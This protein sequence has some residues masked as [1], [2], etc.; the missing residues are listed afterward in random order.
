MRLIG[1]RHVR[2]AALLVMLV[3]S[4]AKAAAQTGSLSV[5]VYEKAK[6]RRE[7]IPGA[8][9]ELT[10]PQ[11][12][13]RPQSRLTGSDGTAVFAE[14]PAGRGFSISVTAGG[15]SPAVQT[16][17]QITAGKTTTLAITLLS[18]QTDEVTIVDKR[19]VVDVAR[20]ESI[21]NLSAEYFNDLPVYGRDYQNVLVLAPGVND[22]DGDGNVTVHGSR[23]RD[24]KVT[25]DGV[26][27]VD[28]LTGQRLSQINPDAIDEIQI[29]DTGADLSMG[30]AVGGYA[31]LTIKSGGN[32]FEGSSSLYWVDAA[33]NN[34]GSGDRDPAPFIRRKPS[35]YVSGPIVRDQLWYL[36]T[37]EAAQISEPIN[38]IGGADAVQ[39]S[40]GRTELAKLTWQV[41]GKSR[42]SIQYSADPLK[43]E[44]SG[45]T[46]LIPADSAADYRQGGPT[47][48]MRWTATLSPTS[49]WESTA[50]FSDIEYGF[51]PHNPQARNS[52]A[53]GSIDG[54]DVSRLRCTDSATGFL[55]GPYP[56]DYSDTRQRRSYALDGTKFFGA[57][58]S[59]GT[60]DIKYGML[61]E[62][63]YFQRDQDSRT[64]LFKA[65]V[66]LQNLTG[67][68][69]NNL[70]YPASRLQLTRYFP[71]TQVNDVRGNNLA[72]YLTD[73][74]MPTSN[75]VLSVGLRLNREELSAD[76]FAP[77]DPVEERRVFEKA[78]GEC[79]AAGNNSAVCVAINS[80]LFTADPEDNPAK[81]GACSVALNP[82]QCAYLDFARQAGRSLKFRT[83][84][85]YTLVNNNLSRTVRVSWDPKANAR[86]Q[87]SAAYTRL[88]GDAFFEPFVTEQG[89]RALTNAY[90]VNEEGQVLP[91]ATETG[92]AFQISQ[93]DRNLNSQYQ[94]EV[95][96]EFVHEIASETSIRLRYV[97][98]RYE[99]QY[100]D[101]DINH[102]PVYYDDLTPRQLS[103]FSRCRRIGEFADC[104]GQN[105]LQVA[106][107]SARFRELPDGI[108][109][110]QLA[111]PLFNNI[112]LIGNYNSSTYE[113]YVF[114]LERRFYQNWEGSL[115]Y[116]WSR[117]MG[118]AEDF[119]QTLGNDAT[120]TDDERGPLAI[121]QTHVV[122]LNGRVLIG[123]WG[124]F[125]LGA[126]VLYASGLPYSIT[127]PRAVIDFPTDLTGG[128]GFERNE[129]FETQRNVFPTGARNDRR[130]SAAW[131]CD[132]NFQKEFKLERAK[133]TFQVGAFN[134]LNSNE[135]QISGVQRTQ[136][137]NGARTVYRDTPSA[138]RA[139]GRYFEVAIKL[140]F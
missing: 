13:F 100:Q 44:P 74:F 72:L 130:N 67:G 8:T 64:I 107:G 15:Y 53:T 34:D 24:F 85:P 18:A 19:P 12:T 75:L 97:N 121:D 116:V 43:Q 1:P 115:S 23:E 120:N 54:A 49:V 62:R 98:R 40:R 110:L 57:S 52:C 61:L 119:S 124:G 77:I 26:S 50:A 86:T 27:N 140:N 111:S 7:S 122:K 112:Y 6:A 9:V 45:V 58:R 47:Y 63:T 109:D 99:D 106:V 93:V 21:T 126:S 65:P 105:L 11:S 20:T 2:F 89:P 104:T 81:V 90:N 138:A 92:R 36:A 91:D 84:Q 46:T 70:R 33:L 114:Q 132:V 134:L 31:R 38:V 10:R 3:V 83:S 103:R 73:S 136:Q 17:I 128:A 66:A 60:H 79:I 101:T 42:L 82:R 137:F 88:Y 30:G 41:N 37:L 127:S 76:G 5:T 125:R 32:K 108:P 16:N 78:V 80:N 4:T 51:E 59:G 29:V 48:S 28:P 113:A 95:T 133:A 123:K 129:M 118:Q 69:L 14:L 22:S 139:F 102:V 56:L 39:E 96:L 87:L 55:S 68:L 25:V 94:D 131:K 135:L 35:A 117:S 71:S